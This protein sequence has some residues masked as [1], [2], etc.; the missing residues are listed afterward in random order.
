VDQEQASARGHQAVLNGTAGNRRKFLRQ[1]G[2][3]GATAAVVG[4]AE[5]AGISSAGAATRTSRAAGKAPLGARPLHSLR[6]AKAP[7][8]A[9]EARRACGQQIFSCDPGHCGGGCPTNQWCFLSSGICG[10]FFICQENTS[11]SCTFSFSRRCCP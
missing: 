10:S 11:G 3:A 7:R 6:K 8:A 4:I 1:F 9:G 5:V 2:M